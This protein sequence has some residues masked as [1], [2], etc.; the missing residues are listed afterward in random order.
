MTHLVTI[1]AGIAM[2]VGLTLLVLHYAT[3]VVVV[4]PSIVAWLLV[5]SPAVGGAVWRACELHSE[6]PS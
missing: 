6:G 4:V 2:Q 3:D 5:V 1:V